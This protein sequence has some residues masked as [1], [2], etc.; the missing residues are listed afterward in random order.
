MSELKNSREDE[1]ATTTTYCKEL[2]QVWR[3]LA[4]TLEKLKLSL[5]CAA[6]M[7][8]ERDTVLNKREELRSSAEQPV[9]LLMM[10]WLV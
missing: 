6:G 9:G 8:K 10:K 7:T 5:A 3:Y 1:S 4:G 2:L